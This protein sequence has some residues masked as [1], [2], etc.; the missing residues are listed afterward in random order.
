MEAIR[1]YV[2][3]AFQGVKLT[4][5]VLEQQEELV[6]DLTAKVADLVAEGKSED[7]AL[8]MAIASVGDLTALVAEFEAA[9]DGTVPPRT[10]KVLANALDLH[11]IAVSLLIG[12]AVMI[13]STALGALTDL[14][15][16][17][18]GFSLLAVL[19]AGVW[20]MRS[21]YQRYQQSPSASETRILDYRP[22]YRKAL[23]IWAAIF[24]GTLIM[25]AATGGEFWC[26]PFWVAGG[27]WALAVKVEERLVELPVFRA[28]DD[29][30]RTG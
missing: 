30:P 11:V 26:W 9:E 17:S 27:T 12:G 19:G 4:P 10:A 7:E 15:F 5:A 1:Y 20:W 16:V 2:H 8:G 28:D 6:A 18:A 21:A 3:G 13:V 25:N 14:V 23:G 24:V 22:R 29:T